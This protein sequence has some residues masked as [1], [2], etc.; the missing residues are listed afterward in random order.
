MK[1][2]LSLAAIT[3][4]LFFHG[5]AGPMQAQQATAVSIAQQLEAQRRVNYEWYNDPWYTS[6]TGSVKTINDELTRLRNLYSGYTFSAT[7]GGGLYAFE[8][9]Y[10]PVYGSVIYSNY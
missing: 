3:A 1:K 5:H 4:M 6:F 9:G 10:H 8:W 2:M 7:P